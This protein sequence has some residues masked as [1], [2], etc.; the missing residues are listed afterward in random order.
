MC[1]QNK[2]KQ[3]QCNTFPKEPTLQAH[4]SSSLRSVFLFVLISLEDNCEIPLTPSLLSSVRYPADCCLSW[5]DQRL[6]R[7]NRPFRHLLSIRHCVSGYR[8][9]LGVGWWTFFC[10]TFTS[11]K[12]FLRC[13]SSDVGA[14]L[15]QGNFTV[16]KFSFMLLWSL[17]HL[18]G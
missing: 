9:K 8:K 17:R 13:L 3:K 1:T 11:P 12:D 15:T 2:G 7:M 18:I 14:I 4:V 16:Y 6:E 10:E 5:A